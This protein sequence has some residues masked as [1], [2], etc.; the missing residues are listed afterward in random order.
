MRPALRRLTAVP[1]GILL[2]LSAPPLALAR[3]SLLRELPQL[4]RITEIRALSQDQASRGYPVRVRATV[5]HFDEAHGVDLL[6]HDGEFGQYILPP[7]DAGALRDWYRIRTGDIIEVE[8]R[9]VRGGF[10]PNVAP[11]RLRVVGRGPLPQ[12]RVVPYAALITGRHD[13]DYVQIEGVVQRVWRSSD[14]QSGTMFAEV[15]YEGGV[16]RALFWEFEA[17]DLNRLTD[18]R[19]RLHGNLGAIFG[20][21]EQLRGVSLFAGRTSDVTILEPAVDPFAQPPRPLSS[22]Y[23]Y[24]A[25]GEVTRRIRV[26]GVVTCYVRGHPV[27]VRD[28]TTDAQ[29]RSVRHVFY[30]QDDTGAARIETENDPPLRPGDLVEVAGFATVSPGR[31]MLRNATVQPM[32]TEAQPS[33]RPVAAADVLTAEND[34]EL[35]RIEARLLSVLPGPEERVLVLK[36]GDTVFDVSL[37]AFDGADAMP[38]IRTDSIVAVTGVYSYQAGPPPS[39]RLYVRSPR[40]LVVVEAAPWWTLR[41][42]LVMAVTL[43][44]GAVGT[45]FWVRASARRRR[46]E[47][48]AVLSERTRVAREL[49]DTL[50]QELVGITM[51]LAAV[52]ATLLSSPEAARRSLEVARQMLRYSLEETRRSVMDLR[53]QALETRDLPGAL[54]SLAGQ[55]TVGTPVRAV[56]TVV[57]TRRR[58]DA[59]QEHHLLRI[60]LE[61]LTNA[62]K[63]AAP[64]RIDIELR[65]DPAAVTLVAR[66]NG[67]GMGQGDTAI[68]SARL[69]LQGV[70][71]RAIKLG[72]RLTIESQPGGGTTLTVTVP[73]AVSAARGAA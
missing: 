45:T 46:H 11:D 21:S 67:C 34:A 28:F 69:G 22:I 30:I 58:L 65:F 39:F 64:T 40:D 73:T 53:S 38:S 62:L 61:A 71:E 41:H 25:T 12:A 42:W 60:G 3:E 54:A 36:S 27:E 31:P 47:Y 8:G 66:D 32:G 18:A 24:S 2:M 43:C 44:L 70:R 10:A 55:M 14:P 72:G 56:V 9:T 23:H 59:A 26:R 48:Q 37:D 5:T 17:P 33:P 16:V 4:T 51:Q 50:E 1:I 68:P 20:P 35:V 49:H 63:H 29:F 7:T 15:A 19:V 13:C 57:G 6:I 52:D